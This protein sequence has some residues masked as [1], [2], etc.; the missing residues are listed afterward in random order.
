MI[1]AEASRIGWFLWFLLVSVPIVAGIA[2]LVWLRRMSRHAISVMNVIFASG[3]VFF[4]HLGLLVGNRWAGSPPSTEPVYS[5]TLAL[6][7]IFWLLASATLVLGKPRATIAK[8][9]SWVVSLVCAGLVAYFFCAML[10]STINQLRH[11]LP[12]TPDLTAGGV[13]AYVVVSVSIAMP[14]ALSVRLAHGLFQMRK[15]ILLSAHDQNL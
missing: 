7:A 14:L 8:A 6:P 13:F 12:D 3:A 2:L 1:T 11:P 10:F 5:L 9:L 4:S 15:A